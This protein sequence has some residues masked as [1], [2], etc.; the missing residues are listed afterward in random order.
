MK[1][2]DKA[3]RVCPKCG[4]TYT[5]LSAVASVNQPALTRCVKVSTGDPH[6]GTVK[7]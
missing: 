7:D 4:R 3:E 5:E 6:A 2:F 1:Q